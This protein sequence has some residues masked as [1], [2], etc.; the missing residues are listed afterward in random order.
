MKNFKLLRSFLGLGVAISSFFAV[1]SCQNE[2]PF[3]DASGELEGVGAA[4]PVVVLGASPDA[5]GNSYIS[6]NRTLTSDTCYILNGFVRVTNGATLTINAGTHILGREDDGVNAP[7]NP[8]T[9]I[10]E[11]G[12][13]INAVGTP[14]S[15]V[16]FS[17]ENKE[18]GAWGGVIILGRASNNLPGGLGEI[19]GLP[20][21]GT[22][23]GFYGA[24][25][26]KGE[27]FDD[28]DNSGTLQYVRI[29]YAGNSIDEVSG[30]ETNGLTLG[31]VG[32]GTTLDHV[33]VSYGNDDAFEFF[34]GTVDATY[35]I[36]YRNRD[37]N[38]D[39]DQGYKGRI[40][41]GISVAA[42][43]DNITVA[44]V[45]GFESNG[46]SDDAST[47][48]TDGTFSNFTVIGPIDPAGSSIASN[49][50]T[51]ALI[52]D[53]SEL[54]IFNSIIVGYPAYQLELETPGDFGSVV[55]AEGVTLVYPTYAGFT[56]QG[57][58]VSGFTTA[59]LN[60]EVLS[61]SSVAPIG[62]TLHGQSGLKKA[63]WNIVNSG[64]DP[65][66]DFVPNVE[67]GSDFTSSLL[68]SGFFNTSVDF[69]GA[70]GSAGD[71][72]NAGWN[73]S[74][75]WVDWYPADNNYCN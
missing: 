3:M 7:V 4:K 34:G 45:N 21:P 32:N 51:G 62:A 57:T 31:S 65:V 12:A 54:D 1:V 36:A 9:L 2:T 55:F 69:R 63:A 15:P 28:A 42:P 66:P 35:L 14:S 23:E 71:P 61:A 30:N 29:E 60:N 41:F 56:A 67:K 37:D 70:F 11:R 38:F 49:Y 8:G 48:F 27:S 19:E 22:T 68:T 39:T 75:T 58:N 16:V 25:F 47:N 26:S 44:P 64:S 72:A 17:G 18:V 33:M 43:A 73:I 50:N 46:D 40:Q 13:K 74:S 52:R 59:G 24:D 20:V 10:V 6:S 5:N 53:A